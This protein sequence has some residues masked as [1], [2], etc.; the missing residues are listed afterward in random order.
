MQLFQS[1]PISRHITRIRGAA[2]EIMYLI[3]GT[4]ESV[5]VDTGCGET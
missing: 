2:G 4:K 1:E 5:L 3:E